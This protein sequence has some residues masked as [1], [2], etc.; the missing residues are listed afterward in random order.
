MDNIT[1]QVKV[2]SI[3]SGDKNKLNNIYNQLVTPQSQFNSKEKMDEIYKILCNKMQTRYQTYNP[4]SSLCRPHQLYGSN[5]YTCVGP[6]C[7]CN[8]IHNRLYTVPCENLLN[9]RNPILLSWMLIKNLENYN[10]FFE[11]V[12]LSEYY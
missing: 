3:E 10:L 9:D 1:Q 6:T 7:E 12:I 2:N 11:F 5:A 8:L 4:N